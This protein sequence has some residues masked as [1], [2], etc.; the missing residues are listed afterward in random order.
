MSGGRCEQ[1]SHLHCSAAGA[2]REGRDQTEQLIGLC[3]CV[4][5]CVCVCECVCV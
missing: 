4:C 5:V 2:G 3:V 1:N